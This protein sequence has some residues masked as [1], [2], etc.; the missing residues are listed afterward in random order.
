MARMP[1]LH[2]L[3][4]IHHRMNRGDVWGPNRLDNEQYIFCLIGQANMA[5]IKTFEIRSFR[6]IQ[7]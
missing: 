1:C 3:R 4:A 7:S 5:S 6:K 2:Y